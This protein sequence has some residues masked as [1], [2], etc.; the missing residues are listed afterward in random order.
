MLLTVRFP[1]APKMCVHATADT[2]TCCYIE[3][4]IMQQ[5]S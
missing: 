4:L 5:E 3:P 2:S 1:P